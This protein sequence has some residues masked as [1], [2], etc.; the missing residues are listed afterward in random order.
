MNQAQI[1]NVFFIKFY[2]INI[3]ELLVKVN[4]LVYFCSNYSIKD[5]IR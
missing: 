1:L 5:F 3:T 4:Y 2:L